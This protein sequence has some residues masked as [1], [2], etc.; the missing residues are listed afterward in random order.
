M[1][2]TEV[3]NLTISTTEVESISEVA[4]V[5]ANM[6]QEFADRYGVGYQYDKQQTEED[7]IYFLVKRN[8]VDLESLEI[9]ILDNGEISVDS[10]NGRR[11]ATLRF[12]IRYRGSGFKQ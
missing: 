7:L 11:L 12:D 3:V 6:I 2:N 5:M 1:S 8:I 9:Y 4:S 10:I